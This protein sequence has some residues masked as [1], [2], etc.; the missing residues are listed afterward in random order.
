MM[1][2]IIHFNL[3][4]CYFFLFRVLPYT[5]ADMPVLL[6]RFVAVSHNASVNKNG[7][8]DSKMFEEKQT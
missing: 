1:S 3:G 5:A 6:G 7:L 8:Q 4:T 2:V